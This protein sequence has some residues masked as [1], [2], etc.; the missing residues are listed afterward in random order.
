MA[1]EKHL[2]L[3]ATGGWVDSDLSTEI[4]QV[5]LRLALVFGEVDPIGTLPNNWN[6]A[7][8]TISRTE[9]NWNIDGNWIVDGPATTD[10][11]PGD[12]LNDQAAP[13]FDDWMDT[14]GRS[15]G[16]RLDALKLYPIGTDGKAIP[17]PPFASGT[18]CTL[19]WTSGN[20]LGATAGNLVPINNAIVAS[21]RTG[22]VGRAGR[23]RMF[24][25][26][27]AAGAVS[28]EGLVDNTVLG[29]LLAAQ[30]ALLE[31]V[32]FDGDPVLG[33]NVRP[34][35]T[36]GGYSAYATI[37]QVRMGNV[38]DT[39]NRRRRQLVETYSST[40]VSY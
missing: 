24:I 21:H 37:S 25:P 23:G 4:W 34:I 1:N 22:Q 39:Q 30:V 11:D 33:P 6:P 20:P 18:P 35:V 13:A 8:S 38:W 31:A 3:T 9:T 27:F 7:A 15:T 12:Y 36:G 17:A 29:F 2:L 40:S 19:T 28:A 32:A 26:G 14:A 5:G 10:F 16:V